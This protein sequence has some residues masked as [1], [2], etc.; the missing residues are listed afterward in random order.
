M[1]PTI[2]THTPDAPEPLSPKR[3][4]R[5]WVLAAAVI[6]VLSLDWALS[7]PTAFPKGADTVFMVSQGEAGV[8]VAS[9]LVAAGYMRSKIVFDVIVEALGGGHHIVPG[10]YHFP[11]GESTFGIALQVVR[12]KYG[13]EQIKVTVPEG[14]NVTQIAAL[15][16][17]KIPGFDATTFIADAAPDEG[18]LFPQTYFFYPD[19]T[20][21]QAVAAMRAMF[22]TETA[23]IFTPDALNGKSVA[24][25]VTMASLVEREA[26]GDDDRATIAGILWKRISL[27]MR[28]EV[29]STVDFAKATG[30]DAYNTYEHGGLPPGP[31]ANPGLQAIQAALNP[32]AT[33]YLYYLHDKHGTIH[34]AKTYAEHQANIAKYL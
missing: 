9:A 15:L 24:D 11:S 6:I 8:S 30:D 21:A 19:T 29:D 2:V 7:A 23:G 18:Y 13:I 4:K 34:Y 3:Q 28:L 26:S 25:I 20:P 27:G 32:T 16:A 5:F 17:D 31:I 14:E 33:D 12:G 10:E 1:E 22:D